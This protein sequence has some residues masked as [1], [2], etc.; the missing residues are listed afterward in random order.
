VIYKVTIMKKKAVHKC[1]KVRCKVSDLRLAIFRYK[2]TNEEIKF[3][4][5]KISV[6]Y[7]DMKLYN[8]DI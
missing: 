3:R 4:I 5:Y 6:V 7:E 8:W 2:V 1:T